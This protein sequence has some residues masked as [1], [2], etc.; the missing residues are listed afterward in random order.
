MSTRQNPAYVEPDSD[1]VRTEQPLPGGNGNGP[2][3]GSAPS[4]ESRD[5][6]SHRKSRPTGEADYIH[7]IIARYGEPFFAGSRPK[8]NDRFWARRYIRENELIY[9]RE[10]NEFYRYNTRT[11]LYYPFSKAALTE[12][13][14]ERI[15]FASNSHEEKWNPLGRLCNAENVSGIIKILSGITEIRNPFQSPTPVIICPN[16][17]VR[18][19][20]HTYE[21][22]S[23]PF[24]PKWRKL[25]GTPFRYEPAAKCEK[26]CNPL[27]GHLEQDDRLVLQKYAGQCLIGRNLI[28][29]FAILDGQGAASKT[30]F[31]RAVC[32]VVGPD[33][34]AEL[35][36][37]HLESRF[38]IANISRAS[39]L[40]GPDVAGNFLNLP[41][42]RRMKSLVGGELVDCEFK[43]S[44]FRGK[45]EGTFNIL[46]SPN[47]R[48]RLYIDSDRS[49][50][51]RRLIIV[52]YEKGF[53]GKKIPEIHKML[54]RE[55]GSGILNWC[56]EGLKLL[57]NDIAR[58]G[59][60]EFSE[61]Q[62]ERIQ[63]VLNESDSLRLFLKARVVQDSTGDHDLSTD[64]L[65]DGYA[66][67][68]QSEGWDNLS[69]SVIARR[70]PDHMLE[71]FKA[72][73]SNNLE[74]LNRRCRGYRKVR[75]R[76]DSDD[77]DEPEAT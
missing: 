20:E 13:L 24:N 52:R 11:G 55:E 65:T 73:P 25:Y 72:L 62:K 34:C 41:G 46:I 60:I 21:V 16:Q 32:G 8:L 63:K 6:S 71:L 74:R 31:I 68:C 58:F 19:E 26:F 61:K 15:Y 70:L 69:A 17:L 45:I 5:Q 66:E 30:E 59:D 27:L 7:E 10:A 51:E 23:E 43:G 36:T 57:L 14:C 28:Q 1:E 29:R 64:E 56:L 76:D 39:L 54:L 50:W 18:F 33:G 47:A 49:A 9:S 2:H 37:E 12:E 53:T 75:W 67:Y 48:L 40:Y 77:Q 38:E 22:V 35:R 44:N 3:L 42:A 4:A